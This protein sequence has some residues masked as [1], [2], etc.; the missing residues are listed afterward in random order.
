MFT[1]LGLAR[2]HSAQAFKWHN[3]KLKFVYVSSIKMFVEYNWS[4]DQSVKHVRL[5]EGNIQTKFYGAFL[6][7][8]L[9]LTAN[10][11]TLFCEITGV[12]Y[13]FASFVPFCLFDYKKP[14]NV[15]VFIQHQQCKQVFPFIMSL[16]PL[17]TNPNFKLIFVI[18]IIGIDG[19]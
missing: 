8:D 3:V 13:S 14:M 12:L 9:H 17:V 18:F 11:S 4:H 1:W 16:S 7:F 5:I 6:F 19:R 15:S 2:L 10:F